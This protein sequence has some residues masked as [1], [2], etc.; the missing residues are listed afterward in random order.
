MS[1]EHP[2]ITAAKT[3]ATHDR[4][5]EHALRQFRQGY[6]YLIEDE[7]QF[8]LLLEYLYGMA[9]PAPTTNRGKD[10]RTKRL[11]VLGSSGHTAYFGM[12]E[13]CKPRVGDTLVVSTAA[14]PVG[15][16]VCQLGRLQGCRVAFQQGCS[17][18]FRVVT[19][20][21]SDE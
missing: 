4:C 11:H 12:I 21:E 14:G 7:I 3:R 2:A 1:N 17:K 19:E 6:P 10:L 16:L 20:E 13:Y 5:R 9:E 15:S 8:G 18:R